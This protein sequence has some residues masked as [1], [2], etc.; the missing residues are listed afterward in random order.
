MRIEL[1][2][3]NAPEPITILSRN[4]ILI[5]F[6]AISNYARLIV[7][8]LCSSSSSS[9]AAGLSFAQSGNS[10]CKT[11]GNSSNFVE[12]STGDRFI[13]KF[14]DRFLLVLNGHKLTTDI[15]YERA[16]NG[17]TREMGIL[18]WTQL[19]SAAFP[20]LIFISDEFGWGM[21]RHS[22]DSTRTSSSG[23]KS[24]P[25]GMVSVAQIGTFVR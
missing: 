20:Y 9:S 13:H 14:Y 3:R 1:N 2:A 12:L 16:M 6:K 21:D 11:S 4:H 5:K 17:W 7:V 24:F 8:S 22:F 10:Q 18:E 15:H 23:E 19:R 25:E